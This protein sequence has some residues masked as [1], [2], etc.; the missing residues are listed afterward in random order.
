MKFQHYVTKGYK[1]S[2]V[3]EGMQ[4]IYPQR[5]GPFPGSMQSLGWALGRH[6]WNID[7][8]WLAGNNQLVTC[9][10]M[11]MFP[12]KFLADTVR[13]PA[14]V[15]LDP[16]RHTFCQNRTRLPLPTPSRLG[17]LTTPSSIPRQTSTVF[18]TEALSTVDSR[19]LEFQG[20]F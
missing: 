7:D 16:A 12:S 17:H 13:S 5:T 19:Y 4:C 18:V 15:P 3:Q 6:L 9:S 2:L 10:N 1:E 14:D 11:A 20:T 8:A